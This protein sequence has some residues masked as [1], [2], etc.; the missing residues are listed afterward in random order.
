MRRDR[1]SKVGRLK[2]LKFTEDEVEVNGSVPPSFTPGTLSSRK[3][4][5]FGTF[6]ELWTL[7]LELGC[8]LRTENVQE[9]EFPVPVIEPPSLSATICCPRVAF[10]RQMDA[11][12]ADGSVRSICFGSRP[13]RSGH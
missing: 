13:G 11:R 3:W 5:G 10:F 4:D 12:P 7:S 1:A 9:Q 2:P 8:W 6:L